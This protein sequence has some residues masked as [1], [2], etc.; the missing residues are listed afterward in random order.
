MKTVSFLSIFNK[1]K[2]DLLLNGKP[3]GTWWM[4]EKVQEGRVRTVD[5]RLLSSH[6][7]RGRLFP[8]PNVKMMT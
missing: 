8:A 2:G 6:C 5:V 3:G 4:E 1:I 7:T